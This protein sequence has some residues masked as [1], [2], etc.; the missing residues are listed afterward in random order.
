MSTEIRFFGQFR[1]FF[2][3]QQISVLY[4]ASLRERMGRAGDQIDA[5]GVQSAVDVWARVC[6]EPMPTNTLVAINQEYASP[7]AAVRAGDE[8]AFFPPVTGG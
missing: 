5:D 3:T 7:T 2:M 4:F 8:V 1:S 6:R